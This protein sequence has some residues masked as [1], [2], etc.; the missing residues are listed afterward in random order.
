MNSATVIADHAAEGAAGMGG[1]IGAVG[2]VM[3]FGGVAEAVK[4]DAGLDAGQLGL[5]IDGV[6]PVHVARV[7]KDDGDVGA[8]AGEGGS[9]ASRQDGGSCGAAGGEGGFNVGGVARVEDADGKLAVVGGVRGVEGAGAEVEEDVA[10]ERGFETR[11]ELAVG[12]EAL[13]GEGRG[14][15]KN[16]KSAHAG[17]VARRT[18]GRIRG[19]ELV[20]M[21]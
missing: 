14:V 5:G 10:P 19:A 21:E 7:V 16:G 6:E 9:G 20:S 13:M 1:G 17:M 2:E 12:G 4:H 3:E 8:L 18:G 11:L 15:G